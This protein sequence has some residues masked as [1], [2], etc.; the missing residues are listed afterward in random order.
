[1]AFP[2]ASLNVEGPGEF[3]SAVIE[4][5][6]AL[7]QLDGGEVEFDASSSMLESMVL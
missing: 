3:S 7:L 4:R 6:G 5:Q 2:I 1:M